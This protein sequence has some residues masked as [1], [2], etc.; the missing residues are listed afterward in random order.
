[1]PAP[2]P[3]AVEDRLVYI[4]TLTGALYLERPA[5]VAAYATAFEQLCAEALWPTETR[6]TLRGI[7]QELAA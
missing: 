2:Y 7:A 5:E 1:M 3:D 4:D 6:D